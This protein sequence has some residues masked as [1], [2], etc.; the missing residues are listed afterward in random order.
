M[1]L[2]HVT[3]SL[4]Q[5]DGGDAE[6]DDRHVLAKDDPSVHLQP[7]TEKRSKNSYIMHAIYHACMHALSLIGTIVLRTN[8]DLL[9]PIYEHLLLY[10]LVYQWLY[11]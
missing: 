7:A 6:D 10:S 8:L 9:S 5:H 1:L 4:D 2:F 3:P 11:L